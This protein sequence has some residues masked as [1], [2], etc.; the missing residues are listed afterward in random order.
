V[1]CQK[2]DYLKIK[3]AGQ[4]LCGQTVCMLEV[5]HETEIERWFM[6]LLIIFLYN[7]QY[8]QAHKSELFYLQKAASVY[9][10]RM[11]FYCLR[12]FLNCSVFS[13]VLSTRLLHRFK[14]IESGRRRETCVYEVEGGLTAVTDF[15]TAGVSY[16]VFLYSFET[17][18]CHCK[19]VYDHHC[20]GYT[21][22]KMSMNMN[23]HRQI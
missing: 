17:N 20:I 3:C 12:W 14:C 10:D 8:L 2:E 15:I 4:I 18:G 19:R 9:Q 1:S 7:I 6:I 23:I 5:Y 21:V 16:R 11:L 22:C 13:V